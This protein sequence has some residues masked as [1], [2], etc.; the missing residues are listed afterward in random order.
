M[1][2]RIPLV[3]VSASNRSL[4]SALPDA[5][6]KVLASGRFIQGD[7]T[8]KFEAAFAA[9]CGAKEAVAVDS[10][11]AAIHLALLACGLKPGDEVLTTPFTFVATGTAILHAGLRPSFADI[12]PDDLNL[13][14]AKA[15]EAI[16]PRT[17]A[18]MPVHLFGAMADM[19]ALVAMA[20]R[21]NLAVIEDACQAHG[22]Y[23]GDRRAGS[24]GDAATF[25]FYPSKNLAAVGDGGAL[26]T[27]REDV[28]KDARL[29]RDHGR[30]SKYEHGLVGFNYRMDEFQAAA[31]NVKLPRLDEWNERRRQLAARYHDALAGLPVTRPSATGRPVWHLYVIRTPKRDALR[32]RLDK[33]GIETGVHYPLPLHLQ[34]PFKEFGFPKGRFPQAERAADEALSLPMYPELGFDGVDRVADAVRAFFKG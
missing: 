10:G 8:K 17:R 29:R 25:S 30:T 19:T 7:E 18:I 9:Y 32:D 26:V 28:A 6:Q 3:D 33:E 13:D 15:E 16:T 23:H 22:A 27:N 11:T 24:I 4:G 20:R 2:S 1:N 31:L 34:P 14:P 12:R 21:R 5:I